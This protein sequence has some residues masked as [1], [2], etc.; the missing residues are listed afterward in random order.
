MQFQESLEIVL[1]MSYG[2]VDYDTFTSFAK[3]SMPYLLS[4]LETM[5]QLFIIN[6]PDEA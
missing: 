4:L 6:Q 3:E 1:S 5:K 2:V